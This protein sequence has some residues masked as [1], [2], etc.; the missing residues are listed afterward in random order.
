MTADVLSR[1]RARRSGH[2]DVDELGVEA[3]FLTEA[4]VLAAD[5]D[6]GAAFQWSCFG[7]DLK[8]KNM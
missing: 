8:K 3:L 2:V 7:K 4:E 6:A 1:Q 5:H